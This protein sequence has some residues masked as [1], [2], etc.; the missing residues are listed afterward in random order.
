MIPFGPFAP[1]MPAHNGGVC[2][3]ATNVVPVPQGYG[4]VRGLVETGSPVPGVPI[5]AFG[6]FDPQA[7]QAS[8]FA[9]TANKIYRATEI[10]EDFVDL[11]WAAGDDDLLVTHIEDIL[12]TG[13]AET[14]TMWTDVTATGASYGASTW[15][16]TLMGSAVIFTDYADALQVFDLRTASVFTPL[17]P[18]VP[19]GKH[20]ATV[21]NFVMLGDVQGTDGVHNQRVHWSAIEDPG[22]WPTPGTDEAVQVQS[23]YQDLLGDGGSVT[24]IAPALSS[25]DAVIFQERALWRCVYVGSP[26]VFQFDRIAVD[27]GLPYPD[28]FV[29]HAGVVYYWS[30]RGFHLSDGA[31]VIPI[32]AAQDVSWVDRFFAREADSATIRAAVDPTH[33]RVVFSF[34]SL[35]D[36]SRKSLVYDFVL[37]RWSLVAGWDAAL[38]FT[39]PSLGYNLDTLDDILPGGIDAHDLSVD[40]SEYLGGRRSLAAMTPGGVIAFDSGSHLEAVIA[41]GDAQLAE[42]N[43][44]YLSQIW[45]MT[46]AATVY[47]RVSV[48]D[49]LSQQP[50]NGAERAMNRWSI[51]PVESRGRF[52]RFRV[53]I[54]AG[55]A[56]T[57]AQGLTPKV[58][59]AGKWV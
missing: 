8:I 51:V 25:A 52:A 28:A 37:R 42:G 32:G 38:F 31:Q 57:Y 40:S 9:A 46:D 53:R 10:R 26:T 23:D 34:V 24:G 11:A 41:T 20:I 29:S 59:V 21:A 7:G 3:E 55:E 48:R 39:F 12:S 18:S 22:T 27:H 47:A 13:R 4:P 54:P 36:A 19:R 17:G 50:R 35:T 33:N 6:A 14:Q 43:G 1:D 5:Y 58:Q 15:R 30:Q 2:L 45:P 49:N 44:V 56:W 16:G